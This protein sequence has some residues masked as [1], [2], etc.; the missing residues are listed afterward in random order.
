[1]LGGF[2]ILFPLLHP[3]VCAGRKTKAMPRRYHAQKPDRDNLDKAVMDALKGLA[4]N[5]DSQVCA[6]KIEKFI[7]AG[8]E[9]P[10][11]LIRIVE[12]SEGSLGLL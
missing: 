6:G 2:F 11:V 7:A 9:Q 3:H 5:D 8:D 4:W 1:M 10:H 12:L